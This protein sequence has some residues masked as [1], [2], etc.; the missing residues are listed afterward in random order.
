[1]VLYL[2]GLGL[3]GA[4]SLTLE[5]SKLLELADKAYLDAYT[6]PM[7]PELIVGLKEFRADLKLVD[8]G[9]LEDGTALLEEAKRLK[10]AVLSYGDPMVATTHESLAS[11]ARKMGIETRMVHNSSIVCSVCGELGL[12]SYK[13]GKVVSVV[14]GEMGALSAYFTIFRN[15]YQRLHTILLLGFKRDEYLDPSEA[16]RMLLDVESRYGYGAVG[17]DTFLVVCS[18][19]G[20]KDQRL[21][22][23]EAKSLLSKDFGRPPHTLVVPAT[24]HFTELESLSSLGMKAKGN[25]VIGLSERLVKRYEEKVRSALKSLREEEPKGLDDLIEN[26]ECYLEDSLRFLSEG[27]DELALLTLGYAEGLLDSL[28]LLDI[29]DLKW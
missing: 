27:R 11:R 24:L 4:D 14:G 3:D 8:R 18:R 16:I 6:T 22:G 19:V 7:D 29:H 12:H 13:V 1:M 5:G 21:V 9:F 17:E 23:G 28:R 25:E 15:L 10:V 26:V 2:I 20:M